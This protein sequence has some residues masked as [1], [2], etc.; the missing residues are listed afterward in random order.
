MII[1][2]PGVDAKAILGPKSRLSSSAGPLHALT[3]IELGELP[4]LES[5]Y[6]APRAVGPTVGAKTPFQGLSSGC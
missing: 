1:N 5:R 6:E 2:R 4:F 3:P